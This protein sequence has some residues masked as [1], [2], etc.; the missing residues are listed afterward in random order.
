MHKL[1]QGVG[2]AVAAAALCLGTAVAANAQSYPGVHSG[3]VAL[4]QPRN[5]GRAIDA[6]QP[7][8]HDA[9]S[10]QARPQ[11]EYCTRITADNVNIR[12]FPWGSVIGTANHT[13]STSYELAV[14]W[15][16]AGQ[17]WA[18]LIDYTDNNTLGWI[19]GAYVNTWLC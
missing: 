18:E 5:D 9:G 12:R 1:M 8:A 17:E 3:Q 11:Y 4:S 6:V 19:F 16:D 7:A 10:A 15:D 13:D 2:V 14:Q